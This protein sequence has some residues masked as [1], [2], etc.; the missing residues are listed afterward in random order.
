VNLSENGWLKSR[1][2]CWSTNR[3][4]LQQNSPSGG[5]PAG[6]QQHCGAECRL[7]QEQHPLKQLFATR[8][9]HAAARLYS[10]KL[11]LDQAL[12]A[13]ANWRNLAMTTMMPISTKAKSPVPASMS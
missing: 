5:S 12:L 1:L 6:V 7:D 13:A 9:L 3:P 4:R 10:G 8:T 11:M 2:S